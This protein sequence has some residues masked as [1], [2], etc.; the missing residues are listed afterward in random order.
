MDTHNT[1]SNASAPAEGAQCTW[2][3]PPV[4]VGRMSG[5]IYA[6]VFASGEVELTYEDQETEK[7][8]LTPEQLDAGR[9]NFF[10]LVSAVQSYRK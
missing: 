9:D 3:I 5:A 1:T 8:Q 10:S 6:K 2:I 4:I 7:A